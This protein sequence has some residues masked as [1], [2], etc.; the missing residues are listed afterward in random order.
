MLALEDRFRVL[1]NL[2]KTD[3]AYIALREAIEESIGK[4]GAKN[5][6]GLGPKVLMGR[7]NATLAVLD[8]ILG[9]PAVKSR[10]GFA[11]STGSKI[12]ASPSTATAVGTLAPPTAL[13]IGE[14]GRTNPNVG[15]MPH[16]QE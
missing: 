4:L 6:I 5:I 12:A 7:G 10:L 13:G 1:D 8:Q 3:S 11:L 9:L 16:M 15:L 14:S 2:N